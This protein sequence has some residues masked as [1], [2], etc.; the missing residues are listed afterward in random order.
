MTPLTWL[1]TAI[2]LF[3]GISAVVLKIN[4]DIDNAIYSAVWM[5]FAQNIDRARITRA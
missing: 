1:S 2:M 5:V 4:G 3:F